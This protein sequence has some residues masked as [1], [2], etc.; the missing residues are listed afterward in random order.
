MSRKLCTL[1]PAYLPTLT[2]WQKKT[3]S[4]C[5]VFLDS[6]PYSPRSHVNRAWVKT[7]D[8]KSLLTVPVLS[9]ENHST[10]VKSIRI[11][12]IS[13]WFRTHKA[14]L[15]SNY[16][17]SPYFDFYF[18]HFEEFY[19]KQWQEL[20]DLNL[21]GIKLIDRLLRW[22][23]DYYFSSEIKV[24]GTREERVMQLLDRFDCDIYIIEAGAEPYFNRSILESH[25]FQIE[26]IPCFEI[27]YEQQFSG[28]ISNLSIV[29]LVFNEG[30][31]AVKLL[32]TV[33]GNEQKRLKV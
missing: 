3:V 4:D 7:V 31:Y 11:D 16:R 14:S 27:R 20:F 32:K 25:G 17:N 12:P 2:W 8:G 23:K 5:V 13:N 33:I 15:N 19:A 9:P 10:P 22:D 21:G 6:P 30:P 29:D 1:F 26:E 28:F 18:P 24:T